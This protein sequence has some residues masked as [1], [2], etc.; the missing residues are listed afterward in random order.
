MADSYI[1][2][3]I[4]YQ[5]VGPAVSFSQFGRYVHFNSWISS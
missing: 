5:P 4:S 2:I 1:S 3:I